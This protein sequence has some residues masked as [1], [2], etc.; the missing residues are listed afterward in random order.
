MSEMYFRFVV[1]QVYGKWKESR[2]LRRNCSKLCDVCPIPASL[3]DREFSC[4]K[5]VKFSAN[6][7]RNEMKAS[8]E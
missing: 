7:F 2:K 3:A 4:I 5:L 8:L 1:C 6:M